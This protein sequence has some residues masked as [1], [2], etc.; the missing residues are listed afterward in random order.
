LGHDENKVRHGG[1]GDEKLFA[2]N[3][4]TSRG[5]FQRIQIPVRS[6]LQDR[7]SGTSFPLADRFEVFLFM[8][9]AGDGIDHRAG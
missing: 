9:G 1:I 8:F 5:N 4:G 6:C 3:L 2:V 7:D